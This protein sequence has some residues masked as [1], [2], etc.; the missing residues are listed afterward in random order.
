[1]QKRQ[2]KSQVVVKAIEMKRARR[3]SEKRARNA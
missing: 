3:E 2:E 1:M